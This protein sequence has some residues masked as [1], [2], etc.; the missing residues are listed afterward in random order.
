MGRKSPFILPF[1]LKRRESGGY[2][3]YRS[4]AADVRPAISGEVLCPWSGETRILGGNAAI[5]VSFNTTDFATARQRWNEIHAQV[6]LVVSAAT[7]RQRADRLNRSRRSIHCVSGLSDQEIKIL[8]ARLEHRILAEHD[9]GLLD[10]KKRAQALQRDFFGRGTDNPVTAV[11]LRNAEFWHH[12]REA[13][14]AKMLYREGDLEAMS[15][16]IILSDRQGLV[17]DIATVETG[18]KLIEVP[19]EITAIL[20]ENGVELPLDHPDRRKI[21]LALI[22][23]SQRAHEAV[24]K[25]MEGDAT[26]STPEDPGTL[27]VQDNDCEETSQT[28]SAAYENW[29]STQRPRGRTAADYKT[30]IVR[31]TALHGDLPVN[32]I[33]RQ[34]VRTF[35][36]LMLGFPRNVPDAQAHFPIE[37]LVAWAKREKIETLAVTTVNDKAIGA[38]SAIFLILMKQGVVEA[39]PC[40]GMKLKVQDGDR[41]GRV[42]YDSEDLKR[43]FNSPLYAKIPR[44]PKAARAAAGQWLPLLGLYTGARLE[45]L[46]QLRV[47]DLKSEGS[48]HYFDMVTLDEAGG[49]I[50]RKTKS[51]R[52]NI[53][54]HQVLIDCGFLRYVHKLRDAGEKRL[55]KDLEFT[56]EWHTANWSKWWGRWAREHVSSVKTKCFHSFRHLFADSLRATKCPDS[57]VE[58]LMGHSSEKVTGRYGN[59]PDI[60]V[61]N[62]TLQRIS[63]K[64]LDVGTIPNVH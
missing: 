4:V 29:K 20:E 17:E 33:T 40:A 59:G 2:V 38:L 14:Y 54:I 34:H 48:I 44:I 45:E 51:S 61:L 11:E 32:Q 3:Y 26:I 56:E 1:L 35:R 22:S 53:P 7:R 49:R 18:E 42:P 31:F 58:R 57:V 41:E 55:F 63:I 27:L 15:M 9:A 50:R 60:A 30:Q 5:K 16:P 64:G 23:A 62:E 28:L 8:A 10:P 6:E 36:D 37:S 12:H 46:G 52:R 19:D 13:E 39:N 24:M 21:A 43:L 25:R 47:A